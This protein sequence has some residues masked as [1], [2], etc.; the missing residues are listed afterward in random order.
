MNIYSTWKNRRNSKHIEAS[1]IKKEQ[2]KISKWLNN[3]TV[4]RFVTRKWIEVNDLLGGKYSVN[5][6]INFKTPMLR[7]NLCDYSG[8]Y[9]LWKGQ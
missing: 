1:I 8:A 6:T 7:S 3:S 2:R 4:S 9:M 5:K